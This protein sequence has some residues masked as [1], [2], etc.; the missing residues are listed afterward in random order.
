M[1]YSIGWSTANLGDVARINMGQSPPS[2]TI[3]EVGEGIPF[4]QGNAEFGSRYPMPVRFCTEPKKCASSGDILLSVRAPVGALNI[5]TCQLGIGR[6][7]AAITAKSIDARF[8]W[9]VLAQ[10]IPILARVSQGSTFLAVKRADIQRLIVPVPSSHEQRT[11]S[12]ILFSVDEVIEITREILEQIEIVK[13]GFI[14]KIF[15]LGLSKLHS[16]RAQVKSAKET[17]VP[18]GWEELTL[19]DIATVV[20]GGTPKR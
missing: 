5:A 2:S 12:N 6:G 1:T 3:N 15:T 4:I 7:I 10:Q 11:I 16:P 13:S 9:Y 8:L 17:G 19:A 18:S 14:R 20:G